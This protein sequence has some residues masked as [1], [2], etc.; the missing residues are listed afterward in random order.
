MYDEKALKA[1][2]QMAIQMIYGEKTANDVLGMLTSGSIEQTLPETTKSIVSQVS[3]TFKKGGKP[4]EPEVYI[5]GSMATG[6]ELIDVANAQGMVED[7]EDAM[8]LVEAATKAAINQG[9]KDG[10]VDPVALQKVLNEGMP[11]D[12][13]K[14]GT[15]Y[16]EEKGVPLE[17]NNGPVAM[18]QY[19]LQRMKER[20]NGV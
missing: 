4:I 13:Q 3:Q 14:G 2:Q 6:K 19:A 18:E 7:S 10:S 16:A 1:F 9:M 15:K 5:A 20:E 8:P 12:M 17:A 11:E